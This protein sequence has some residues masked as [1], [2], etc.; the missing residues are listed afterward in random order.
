MR[1]RNNPLVLARASDVFSFIVQA[2]EAEMLPAGTGSLMVNS[3]KKLIQAAG[4]DAAGILSKMPPETQLAVQG[5]F[6]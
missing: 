1:Y 6:S 2:L 3:A 4:I 5:F